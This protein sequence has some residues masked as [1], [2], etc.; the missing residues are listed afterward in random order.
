VSEPARFGKY[1]LHRRL[2]RGAQ[3]EVFL[4][5]TSDAFFKWVALKIMHRELMHDAELIELF[6]H[7][8]KLTAS[9]THPN[10]VQT[11]DF[12]MCE[13]RYYMVTE[14]VPGPSLAEL[15]EAAGGLEDGVVVDI[16][17]EVLSALHY[18]HRKHDE[19]G[20]ALGITH[21]DL[22]AHNVLVSIEGAVKVADFGV[23][24][25]S[26]R[27]LVTQ[28]GVLRG[29]FDSMAPERQGGGVGDARS[30]LYSVGVM[31][32]RLLAGVESLPECPLRE[33]RPDLPASLG[34]AIM[35][36]L[37]PVPADRFADAATFAL[38][39]NA[40]GFLAP[41]RHAIA[42]S[43]KEHF[44]ESRYA[45]AVISPSEP[46][47]PPLAPAPASIAARLAEF[48]RRTRARLG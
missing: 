32:Y 43:V 48:L 12:G 3:A 38:A 2:G 42:D 13:H 23:A 22:S 14:Y 6:V 35:R 7:E 34:D 26:T 45:L 10:I 33:L 19:A 41:D 17:K 39:L 9:L 28:E 30:D 20:R 44:A 40:P 24:K 5:R 29:R 11:H 21:R 15:S 18:V 37:A 1:L 27:R 31:A 25:A 8:A 16:I 47:P 4:A 36:A 46:T